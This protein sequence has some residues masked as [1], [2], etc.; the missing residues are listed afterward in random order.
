VSGA[1]IEFY[2]CLPPESPQVIAEENPFRVPAEGSFPLTFEFREEAT[3]EIRGCGEVF[4]FVLH[5]SAE[6]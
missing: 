1:L 5:L 6:P 4:I 2:R 3:V